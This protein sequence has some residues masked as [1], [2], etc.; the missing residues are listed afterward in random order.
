VGFKIQIDEHEITHVRRLKQGKFIAE[1]S[2]REITSVLIKMKNSCSE[3]IK[4]GSHSS[5]VFYNEKDSVLFE[6]YY[7]DEYFKY[8]GSVF[9]W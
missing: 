6:V 5:L 8:K 9:K 2:Q 7:S 3:F 4:F 1:L